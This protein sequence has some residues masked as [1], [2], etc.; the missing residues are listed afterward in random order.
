MCGWKGIERE[1]GG[2]HV[3]NGSSTIIENKYVERSLIPAVSLYCNSIGHV[4][5]VLDSS[6]YNEDMNDGTRE[7]Q[8]RNELYDSDHAWNNNE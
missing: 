1:C 5:D 7:I 4:N 2:G 6:I 3:I 8:T